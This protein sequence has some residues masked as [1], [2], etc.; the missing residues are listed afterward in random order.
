MMLVLEKHCNNIA[1]NW[2]ALVNHY[3]NMQAEVYESISGHLVEPLYLS[4]PVESLL[5]RSPL[6]IAL[7]AEDPIVNSLPKEH[8]L[9]FSAPLHVSFDEALAHLRNRLYVQFSGNRRGLFHYYLPSV[10]SYFFQRSNAVDTA[11]WL[12]CFSGLYFYRQ[13]HSDLANWINVVGE[14][15][16][17]AL[18]LWQLTESQE[19]ALNDKYDESD[20]A[21]WAIANRIDGVNWQKQKMAPLFFSQHQITDPQLCSRLR[22]VIHRYDV[23]LNGLSFQSKPHQTSENIV[24]Q[25]E[26]LLSRENKHVY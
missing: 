19:S 26:H 23:D 24:E 17:Q 1:V 14:G 3:H 6:V 9:Y 10:A 11:K 7:Q 21:Q 12:G 20:I 15:E 5:N 16:L 8:T 18:T 25:L 13:T 4:T 22:H 2:F